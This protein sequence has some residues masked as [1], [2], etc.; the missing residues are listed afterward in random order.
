[1]WS[2]YFRRKKLCRLLTVAAKKLAA[3]RGPIWSSYHS[4]ADI[5]KFLLECRDAINQGTITLDQKNELW[6]IFLPTSD[7]DDVVG[8]A[9]L[10]TEID[11]LLDKLYRNELRAQNQV[12]RDTAEEASDLFGR[13][14]LVWLIPIAVVLGFL[15][16]WSS[17]S[18]HWWNSPRTRNF[19][20]IGWIGISFDGV[21]DQKSGQPVPSA[22]RVSRVVRGGP[23]DRAGMQTER[24][25]WL[26]RPAVCRR[27]RTARQS[28]SNACRGFY[29]AG[30]SAPGRNY[31]DGDEVGVL[32]RNRRSFT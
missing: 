18:S 15:M 16:S 7:W 9:R 4:G 13:K 24:N 31:H 6:G 30:G 27:T 26:E 10:G 25:C 29:E 1:M 12:I 19:T 8:D 3:V 23:A 20:R 11:I 17:R 2:D 5:A 28:R 14:R 22:L 32:A 21:H